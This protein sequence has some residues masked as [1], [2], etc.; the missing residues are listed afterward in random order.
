MMWT[1]I[2]FRTVNRNH[3]VST[4]QKYLQNDFSNK[5]FIRLHYIY[6][7]QDSVVG[8]ELTRGWMVRGLDPGEGNIFQPYPDR[9]QG[10]SSF[11]YNGYQ[12]S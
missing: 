8:T 12:V 9:P 2:T 6:G 7:R 11:L 3:H 5:V 1:G 10:P 4:L